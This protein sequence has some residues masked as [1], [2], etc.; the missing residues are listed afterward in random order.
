MAKYLESEII[1]STRK[2][3]G[4]TQEELAEGICSVETLYRC[5]RG[6]HKLTREFYEKLMRN[7][8]RIGEKNYFILS[9]GGIEA[10]ELQKELIKELANR[11]MSRA[12]LL[13]KELEMVMP[14]EK[15]DA[16]DRQ[17][18]MTYQSRIDMDMGKITEEECLE[19]LK[20]ALNLTVKNIDEIDLDY[21]I[22]TYQ[23]RM[24]ILNIMEVYR[25]IGIDEKAEQFIIKMIHRI[26][27]QTKILEWE[28]DN[29]FFTACYI[30]LIDE[31]PQMCGEALRMAEEMIALCKQMQSSEMVFDL[32]DSILC[33]MRTL[34]EQGERKMDSEMEALKHAYYLAIA[35]G[36]SEYKIIERVWKE[37]YGGKDFTIL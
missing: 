14:E 36:N 34:G 17:F 19:K 11:N 5:E 28:K 29:V 4:M 20:E 37:Q 6:Y 3:L 1:K 27:K 22:F 12:D 31:N 7:M 21:W 26:R 13:L 8:G 9:V 15:W 25:R 33:S 10:Y 2:A 23:E 35:T 24:I 16:S 30:K 18:F 32:Y